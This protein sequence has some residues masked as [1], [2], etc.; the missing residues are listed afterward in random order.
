MEIA[1]TALK[2]GQGLGLTAYNSQLPKEKFL[3]CAE[4]NEPTNTGSQL[5]R[6]GGS[7]DSK[8]EEEATPIELDSSS[9]KQSFRLHRHSCQRLLTKAKSEGQ[10]EALS[11]ASL[12]IQL[13][14]KSEEST[15]GVEV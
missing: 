9:A 3:N 6:I 5:I 10:E 11:K 13:T 1:S 14:Q 7:S 4:V 8:E 15:S 12:W 2:S